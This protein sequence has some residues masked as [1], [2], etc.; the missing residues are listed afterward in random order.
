[1]KL[2]MSDETFKRP[3]IYLDYAATSPVDPDVVEV[4]A[5]CMTAAGAFANAASPHS[6]G[7][8]ARGMIEAA[9]VQVAG[10]V[11]A[12]PER[13]VFTSGATE[14]NNL[15]IKGV[16]RG[17]D[18]ARHLIT[19]RIE[20]RSVLDSA[21]A[22]ADEG[23]E[24]TLL[25]CDS[26][27]IVAPER[28]ADALRPET[29]LVSFMHVNNEVGSV[30]DVAAVA[31]IC[32]DAGVP[33]HVDA[34]Q[35]AG[36][37]PV[38]IESWGVDLCSL[39]AH[40]VNGP[41]GVGALYVREG[42][43]LAPWLHGGEAAL[44]L[45]AGTLPTH[46]I[47][48]FGRA[49]ELAATRG[50]ADRF[51]ALKERLW[52]GLSQIPGARRNGPAARSAPHILNVGFPGVEGES[53]RLALADIAVS[54]GSACTSAS[55]SPSHVLSGMGLSDALAESSLRFGLGRFTTPAEIDQAILRVAAE[56]ARLR[57]VAFSAP[58]WCSS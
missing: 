17:V 46:Q 22:L 15:A 41:K 32:R 1:L 43:V 44:G 24:V 5:S 3:Q 6:A 38:D 34:A 25:D 8:A 26:A 23:V 18:G 52:A 51:A 57:E 58:G 4:M 45:R 48:G 11:K 10:L 29:R 49:F 13:L 53:L 7:R 20:H 54:A 2:A 55:A 30:Q 28:V 35:A 31:R 19:T 40:K 47:V 33:L 27:G 42:V 56:V 36:K 12:R 14:A 39:T 9:R 16:M 21:A 37:V 50:E